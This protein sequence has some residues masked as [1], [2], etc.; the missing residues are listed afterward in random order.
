MPEGLKILYVFN[1]KMR[2]GAMGL[3]LVAHQQVLA[4]ADAGHHVTLVSRGKIRHPNVQNVSLRWTPAN[5]LSFLPAR[6]YYSL[7]SRF[8]SF[9]G[10]WLASNGSFDAIVGWETSSLRLF[11]HSQKQGSTRFLN[12]PGRLSADEVA[13]AKL[14]RKPWPVVDAVYRHGEYER[15]DFILVA[16]ESARNSFCQNGFNDSKLFTLPRGADLN[17]FRS[18]PRENGPFRAVFFGRLNDRKGILQALDVWRA[19]KLENAEFWL[20]GAAEKD[21]WPEIEARLDASITVFGHRNDAE[22]LLTLCHVQILP[23]ASE[24][25]AKTLLEG[26]ACGCVTLA[27]RES[28]FPL[29][30]GVNGFW[31]QRDDILGTASHL[32]RLRGNRALWETMSAASAQ[33]IA[34]NFTWSAFRNRFVEAVH[35]GCKSQR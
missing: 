20:I 11:C 12:A 26:A 23:T 1:G 27:T 10:G 21:L 15:A 9:L 22:S 14:E 3:D 30:D 28:G 13:D 19:A 33:L 29:V 24:G 2:S 17:R 32:N 25:M 18:I 4:L 5:L 6:Y 16:S 34:E 7:Q 35:S 8:F 31:I